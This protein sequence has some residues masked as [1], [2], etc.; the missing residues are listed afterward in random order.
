[1]RATEDLHSALLNSISHE[2]RTPLASIAGVLS[3]LR[4]PADKSP[5]NACGGPTPA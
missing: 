5:G 2:L 3:S 1:M 4:E